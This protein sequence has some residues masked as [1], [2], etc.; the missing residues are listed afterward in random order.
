MMGRG[1][2]FA[3]LAA[4]VAADLGLIGLG[5]IMPD[6]RQKYVFAA[7]QSRVESAMRAIEA[8]ERRLQKK[9][10]QYAAFNATGFAAKSRE[11]AL[12]W[13][14][15]PSDKFQFDAQLLPDRSLRLRALPRG[16]AVAA[17]NVAPR[18]FVAELPPKQRSAKAG[19]YP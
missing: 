5:A 9:T 7:Q 8:G 4:L 12:N 2:S 13:D 6:L 19:W 16:E 18:M 14:A 3:L 10:G 11:L 1:M 17:L 15:V